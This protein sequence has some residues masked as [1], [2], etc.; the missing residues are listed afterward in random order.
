MAFL[1]SLIHITAS[2][3]LA[4]ELPKNES[5]TI[6]PQEIDLT[7][8]SADVVF[9]FVAS[10]PFGIQNKYTIAT[11][12]NGTN[13]FIGTVLERIDSP[14]NYSLKKVTF[15]NIAFFKV[16]GTFFLIK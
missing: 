1:L 5:L 9:E 15:P 8:S 2:S 4:N 7:N 3:A 11:L 13:V 14:I 12:T 10:H 16:S 6:T